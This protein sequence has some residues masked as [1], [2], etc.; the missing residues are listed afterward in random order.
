MSK[1]VFSLQMPGELILSTKRFSNWSKTNLP[2][3]SGLKNC[4]VLRFYQKKAIKRRKRCQE[5]EEEVEDKK[6]RQ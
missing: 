5:E 1:Q 4:T 2:A 6:G 3:K